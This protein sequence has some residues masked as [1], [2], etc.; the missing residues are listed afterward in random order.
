MFEMSDL[1]SQEEFQI[2][3]ADIILNYKNRWKRQYG[4]YASTSMAM[5]VYACYGQNL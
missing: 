4:S 1:I 5:V 3:T 2:T